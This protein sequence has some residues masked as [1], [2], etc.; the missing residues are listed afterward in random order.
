MLHHRTTHRDYPRANS[1]SQGMYA[2]PYLPRLPQGK[3]YQSR[4]VC[5]TIELPTE[6]T[7]GQTVPVKV[8]ML[9][10]R[11]THQD[12]PRKNTTVKV[13]MLHQE[14]LTKI[15]PGQTVPVQVCM[16]HHRTTHRHHSKTYSIF[17]LH[18]ILIQCI[19][20]STYTIRKVFFSHKLELMSR[21][22]SV[23][24]MLL[25]PVCTCDF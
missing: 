10:Y 7:P 9:H 11:N 6:I 5:Y 18:R 4:Y 22:A 15:T 12:Y 3:Q 16:L 17:G 19:L 2:T 23:K 13:C 1:T 8:C 24:K 21:S 25:G 14:L 20:C